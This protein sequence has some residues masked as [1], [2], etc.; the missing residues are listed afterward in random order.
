MKSK[1]LFQILVLFA[2]LFS[3]AVPQ[4]ATLA[5]SDA[6]L[7]AALA[8]SS[9]TLSVPYIDQ[10]WF[11]TQIVKTHPAWK[12]TTYYMCGPASITMALSFLGFQKPDTVSM[13]KS[14]Q[15]VICNFSNDKETCWGKIPTFLA[16]YGISARTDYNSKKN[17]TFS[18]I[19]NNINAG[20]PIIT[21]I[22]FKKPNGVDSVGHIILIVGYADPDIVIVN[23]P[24][25]GKIV[26][27]G[28]GYYWQSNN[29]SVGKNPKSTGYQI[30]YKYSEFTKILGGTWVSFTKVPNVLPP[31][32]TLAS[33]ANGATLPSDTPVTFTWNTVSGVTE[34]FIEWSGTKTGNSGW[35][36]ATSFNTSLPAGTYSWHVKARN[37]AG[38][39]A[40]SVSWTFMLVSDPLTPTL[41]S[42]ANGAVLP[43]S[44]PIT[45]TWIAATNAT[46]HRVIWSGPVSGDSG[47][48][49][50]MPTSYSV[51]LPEGLYNWYV[52]ARNDANIVTPSVTWSFTV[53]VN[54]RD[55]GTLLF[56]GGAPNEDL[57][58]KV[59]A[60]S[61]ANLEGNTVYV[62]AYRPAIGTL[63][64]RFFSIRS[65][66]YPANSS[67]I[68][69]YDLDE[70]GPTVGGV[71]YFT[72]ISL[73]VVMSNDD[74]R[75]LYNLTDATGSCW[76]I[77]NN[78]HLCDK[79]VRP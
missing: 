77:T 6:K 30:K 68:Y 18:V 53:R 76:A 73:N 3:F 50:G 48:I 31:A 28:K 23:D 15:N 45:F 44:T 16:T 54:F 61:N 4:T 74:I 29:G 62:Q 21:G 41:V 70:A 60:G 72:V 42:P 75:N 37:A 27:N 2:L 22:S 43:P 5:A 33:P 55:T 1:M 46:A 34:Y 40:W 7:P 65:Q 69:F 26:P 9:K 12:S 47:W 10:A 79:G 66:T 59:C 49:N 63:S 38:E 51:V 58:L 8:G 14:T 24:Y 64:E 11:Q 39:S 25:G 71:R 36:T 17:M 67:C 32:P 35:I 56:F 20:R 13:A 19:K 52:E 78:Y 57:N